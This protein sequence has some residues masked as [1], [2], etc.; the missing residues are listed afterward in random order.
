MGPWWSGG[1][2]YLC[3]HELHLPGIVPVTCLASMALVPAETWLPLRWFGWKC[4]E[5]AWRGGWLS[6]CT[7]SKLG[8]DYSKLKS[9]WTWRRNVMF[10]RPEVTVAGP[11]ALSFHFIWPPQGNQIGLKAYESDIIRPYQL[12]MCKNC[13]HR[14]AAVMPR[15][16]QCTCF[17]NMGKWSVSGANASTKPLQAWASLLTKLKEITRSTSLQINV[18]SNL[19]WSDYINL[20][21]FGGFFC[22][23]FP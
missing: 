19:C 17:G 10:S 9:T 2:L 15:A 12:Y 8:Q 1:S 13:N 23:C 7:P 5:Q 6:P 21:V 3:S 20:Q 18:L 4:S 11:T 16:S 14:R 22:G